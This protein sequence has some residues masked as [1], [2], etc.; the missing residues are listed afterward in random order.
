MVPTDEWYAQAGDIASI[1]A[2]FLR[3]KL[4]KGAAASAA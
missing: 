2:E 3:R 1:F 4:P